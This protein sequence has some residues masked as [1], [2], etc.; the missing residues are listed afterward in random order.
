MLEEERRKGGEVKRSEQGS[1][2]G[3]GDEGEKRTGERLVVQCVLG[4]LAH[5][6]GMTCCSSKIF[7][8]MCR[9]GGLVERTE[10]NRR[11]KRR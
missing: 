4:C 9:N 7:P 3:E 8:C 6:S 10:K 11:Q 2:R 5:L 1:T